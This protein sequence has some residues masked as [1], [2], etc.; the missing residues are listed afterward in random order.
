M[1][2]S[3]FVT[4][5][6]A[7]AQVALVQYFAGLLFG[8]T[9]YESAIN[10]AISNAIGGYLTNLSIQMLYNGTAVTSVSGTAIQRVIL[11]NFSVNL[12]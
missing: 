12:T 1:T 10:A 3:S 6:T 4:S 8:Q 2:Y 7:A 11:Q 9:A 5:A